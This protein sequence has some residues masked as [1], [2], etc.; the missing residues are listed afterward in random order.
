VD[1]RVQ[2]FDEELRSLL[3]RKATS[4]QLFPIDLDAGVRRGWR[5]MARNATATFLAMAL[6]AFAALAGMRAVDRAEPARPAQTPGE[7]PPALSA[8]VAARIFLPVF[9]VSLA[10]GEGSVWVASAGRQGSHEAV[11]V[12]SLDVPPTLSRVDPATNAVAGTVHLGSYDRWEDVIIAFGSVWLLDSGADVLFRLDPLTGAVQARIDHLPGLTHAVEGAGS[13]WVMANGS[14][15]RIDPGTNRVTGRVD[16]GDQNA[17]HL[18][19]GDGRIWV[20]QADGITA[21]DAATLDVVARSPTIPGGIAD[22]AFAGGAA[23]AYACAVDESGNCSFEILRVGPSGGIDRTLPVPADV[24]AIE[25]DGDTLW[26]AT[27]ERGQTTK[28][29]AR[30][31]R[32]LRIDARTGEITGTFD[33]EP[34]SPIAKSINALA[35]DGNTLWALG[36]ASELLRIELGTT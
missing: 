23:W 28:T 20:V 2:N 16:F 22:V 15:L 9:S 13:I 4:A 33:V 19:Y 8:R 30:G 24:A 10:V 3:R 29:P 12:P 5:R 26:V 32:I 31:G 21:V 6:L 14:L 36:S 11:N 7:T 18:S 1:S 27:S 34:D 17:A 35:V 25:G